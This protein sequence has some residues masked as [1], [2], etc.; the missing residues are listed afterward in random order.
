MGGYVGAE[1]EE[2]AEGG[3]G[4]REEGHGQAHDGQ[5]GQQGLVPDHAQARD[6]AREQIPAWEI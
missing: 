5:V 2:Q 1:D 3:A 4:E 6:P